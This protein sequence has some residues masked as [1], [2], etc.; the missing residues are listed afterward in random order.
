MRAA[1]RAADAGALVAAALDDPALAIRLRAATAV[2]VIAA[3]KAAAAML[4]AFVAASTAASLRNR[5]ATD[6]GTGHPLPNQG[7][8]AAAA[9]AL[10][11]AAAAGETDLLVLLLS[12]GASAKLAMPAAGITLDDKRRTV[13][14]LL[15]AGANIG[16][17]NAVRRHVSALKGGQLAASTA[18]RVLT[19]AVSDVVGDDLS[20]IAS[21]P[22]VADATTFADALRVLDQHGGRHAYPSAV[23]ARLEQGAAG[24]IPDTP[25]PGDE[26]LARSDARVIGNRMT[27]V[28]GAGA[29]AAAL[30]YRVQVVPEPVVGEARLA[31]SAVIAAATAA[32]LAVPACVISSGETTVRVTGAGKG[33]RNQELALAFVPLVAQLGARVALASVGTDGID[34]P[35]DAAG[36]IVDSTTQARAAALGL[37]AASFLHHNNAYVFFDRLGDLIRTGPTRTNVG[38]LQIVLTT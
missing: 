35:T 38:D 27:A 33:G 7:S 3:G 21:G 13:Q 9:R 1:L 37:E 26:R 22:A 2:D 31:A 12:G 25:K 4:D 36:A 34:G 8:V 19:L 17:L 24:R 29:A 20:V 18:A 5:T 32:G 14:R 28:A 6:A 10:D 11:I 15:D 16:E 23:V 30:G